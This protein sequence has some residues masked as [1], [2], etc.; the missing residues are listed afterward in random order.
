MSK[1]NG[2]LCPI[3]VTGSKLAE[4]IS[5]LTGQF[6]GLTTLV[7]RGGV[8]L[9]LGSGIS[10]SKFPDVQSLIFRLLTSLYASI[11]GANPNCPFKRSLTDILILSGLDDFSADMDPGTYDPARKKVLLRQLSDKYSD[12]LEQD[13][14]GH[15]GVTLLTWDLLKLQ[16]LYSNPAI[17]PDAEHR[18]VALLVSEGIINEI[19][20]TNWD[21]LIELAQ[22]NCQ[23]PR[24][25]KLQIIAAGNEWARN[26]HPARLFK[27]HGCARK[28]LANEALY[29]PFLIATRNQLQRWETEA[30]FEPFKTGF[31]QILRERTAFFIG[32]SAQDWNIQGACAATACGQDFFPVDPP[33][34]FFAEHDL[35]NSHRS[36]MRAVY[37]AASYNANADAI[38][39]KA[40]VPAFGKTVCGSLYLLTVQDKVQAAI[41][42]AEPELRVD[43]Q[44]LMINTVEQVKNEWIAH[45]DSVVDEDERWRQ[46]ASD[47]AY[48]FSRTISLFRRWSAPATKDEYEPIST[49]SPSANADGH[50]NWA[51]LRWLLFSLVLLKEGMTQG[52][53][54]VGFPVDLDGNL[55]QFR[56]T[57]AASTVALFLLDQDKG[58]PKLIATGLVDA[59]TLG[60]NIVM[61]PSERKNRKTRTT[62]PARL[63]PGR[64]GSLEP[65]EMWLRTDYEDTA[66]V[67][68]LLESLK[69]QFQIALTA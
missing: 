5:L 21:P 32:L 15:G 19:V 46:V 47:M 11:D 52:H 18:F 31:R 42:A 1:A 45:F 20:T 6:S 43:C 60:R 48:C 40:C 34:V 39:A 13:I 69:I 12:V 41:N 10:R 23:G 8:A 30:R 33:K 2:I 50:Q 28:A 51:P 7:M 54:T 57:D 58:L 4:G 62:T 22:E 44:L 9:W 3:A 36:V 16:E 29:R 56:L 68:E 66:S 61:Y 38:D 26:G 27:M 53:W 37:G 64:T 55:G 67:N 35:R 25:S 49:E 24:P 59:S 65:T 17:V 63:L 14:R